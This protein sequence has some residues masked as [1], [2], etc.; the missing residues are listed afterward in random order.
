VSPSS[1]KLKL[2]T[3]LIVIALITQLLS[4]YISTLIDHIVHSDLYQYGLEFDYSWANLYWNNSHLL[5]ASLAVAASLIAISTI[6][7]IIHVKTNKKS[8]KIAT[9]VFSLVTSGLTLFSAYIFTRIDYIIHNTLY[10][11][12]LK[13]NLDWATPYWTYTSSLFTLIG[14]TSTL[15]LISPLLIYITTKLTLE[16]PKIPETEQTPIEIK[17]EKPKPAK[18]RK[19]HSKN[20]RLHL[21]SYLLIALGAIAL[22]ES[23]HLTSSIF[24]FLGLGL[25]FWGILFLYIRT[26]E[27]TKKALLDALA[28]SQTA[29]LNQIIED[30]GYKGNAVY[31]PPKY[32]INPENIKVYIPKQ[33]ETLLPTPEQIQKQEKQAFITNPTGL[34]ITPIGAELTKLFEKTLGINFAMVDVQYLQQNFPSLLIEE[35]EVLQNFEMETETQKITIKIEESTNNRQNQNPLTGILASAFACALAKATGNP[36]TIEKQETSP[37]GKETTI[38]YRIMMEEAR[39]TS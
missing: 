20:R 19:K 26:E 11:Y 14:I 6:S 2:A 31:L 12:G 17:T 18:T 30:M 15:V 35:L 29:I 28:Y 5:L 34:L 7:I 24:A 37:D 21:T 4:M 36:I 16:K 39:V 10:N 23:I 3:L 9:Y 8:F 32:F 1:F 38:E 22:F 25:L 33:N 13:F 27:Y